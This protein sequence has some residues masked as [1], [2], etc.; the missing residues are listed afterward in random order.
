MAYK[1]VWIP[2]TGV[3]FFAALSAYDSCRRRG[4]LSTRRISCEL[5]KVSSEL[6]YVSA[7]KLSMVLLLFLFFW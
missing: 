3:A 7:G 4:L 5:A 1:T 6:V 2:L